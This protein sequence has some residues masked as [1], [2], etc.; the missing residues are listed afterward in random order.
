MVTAHPRAEAVERGCGA[1]VAGGVYLETGLGPGGEPLEYFLLDPP[2]PLATFPITMAKLGVSLFEHEGV[3]HVLD[4]VGSVHYGCPADFLEEVRRFG[5]SRR[6]QRTLDFSRLSP[7]SRI[8]IAHDRGRVIDPF[9]LLADRASYSASRVQ[10]YCP[11]H[12][13]DHLNPDQA[14]PCAALHWETVPGVTEWSAGRVVT[15]IMPSFR[16]TAAQPPKDVFPKFSPAVVA[17]FPLHAIAVING[18]AADDAYT[19]AQRSSLPVYRAD[20]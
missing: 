19:A 1:R 9:P 10:P 16:Y 2:L 5:L 11:K 12:K 15:R 18:G 3:T 20:R 17:W 14:I 6:A 8:F 7:A 4:W 13:P